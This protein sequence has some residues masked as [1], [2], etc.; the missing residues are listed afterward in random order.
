M[1]SK[2]QIINC[3]IRPKSII[4]KRNWIVRKMIRVHTKHKWNFRRWYQIL[5]VF[6]RKLFWDCKIKIIKILLSNK[7]KFWTIKWRRLKINSMT[8]RLTNIHN[9]QFTRQE[10][11]FLKIDRSHNTAQ[12]LSHHLINLGY[13]LIAIILEIIR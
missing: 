4:L 13:S 2:Q 10:I 11:V 3:S 6:W 5:R 9:P 8:H 1:H 7:L 12:N